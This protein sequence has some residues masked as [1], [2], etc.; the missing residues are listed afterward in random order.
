M[1][2]K[3]VGRKLGRSV[4]PRVS[5]MRSLAKSLITSEKIETTEA[6]AREVKKF[7]EKIITR[8]KKGDLHSR[9]VILSYLP[10]PTV[11]KKIF[12]DIVPRYKERPGGYL[13][14]FKSRIRRGDS[15]QLV[16]LKLISE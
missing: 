2:H 9:R 1:R 5:L 16:I 10:N 14:I 13:Q 6:K 11:V 8:A 4:G 15:A 7:V 12:D 3:K